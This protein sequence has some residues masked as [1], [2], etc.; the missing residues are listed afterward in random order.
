[1]SVEVKEYFDVKY[2]NSLCLT[3]LEE[4]IIGVDFV[5]RTSQ[6]NGVSAKVKLLKNQ[7]LNP[8]STISVAVGGSVM[9]SFLHKR[10]YYTG[11]HI[12]VLH[13]KVKLTEKQLLYYCMCLKANKYRYNYGRQANKTLKQIKI[14]SVNEIPSWVNEIKMP[15][16][17]DKNPTHSQN[18]NLF[19]NKWGW[20]YIADLFN[21]KKGKRLVMSKLKKNGRYPFISSI[22]ENNGI[23][24][25]T[26]IKPNHDGNTITVNYNGS[27]AEAFY[28]PKPFWASDDVNVLYPKFELNPFIAMFLITLIRLEKYRFNYGR[29]WHK[30]RME[31]SKIKLPVNENGDTDWMFMENYIKSLP[32]S[33]GLINSVF[34][35]NS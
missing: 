20:F 6:N 33:K 1:M 30:E 25:M 4:D 12:L 5:S 11:Y 26:N 31:K 32:Y 22:S 19:E 18:I 3:D 24:F 13:P 9:E 27:V 7:I 28:Q 34:S 14:P 29:K 8:E 35:S 21:I 17:P 2:G 16:I 23:K 10:P 15:E